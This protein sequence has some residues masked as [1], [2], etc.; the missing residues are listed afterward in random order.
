M[1]SLIVLFGFLHFSSSYTLIQPRQSSALNETASLISSEHCQFYTALNTQLQ[2]GPKS[3]LI[4]F[5]YK[6]CQLLLSIRN[7]FENTQY[8]DNTRRCL[9]EKLL[10]KIQ[11]LGEAKVTCDTFKEI[12]LES[13]GICL[14][15]AFKE[16]SVNDVKQFLAVFKDTTVNYPQLCKM[17]NG[18]AGHWSEYTIVIY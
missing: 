17:A 14:S 10:A 8:Q 5:S 4:Q 2:C 15:V 12:D 6:Y 11:K 1:L 7:T 9:Q 16:L 18:F 13:H 3:H